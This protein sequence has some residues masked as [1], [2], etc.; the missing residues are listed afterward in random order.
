MNPLKVKK[1]DY[2]DED[3]DV[4]MYVVCLFNTSF[5]IKHCLISSR[6]PPKSN[7]TSKNKLTGLRANGN[8]YQRTPHKLKGSSA[9]KYFKGDAESESDSDND[10]PSNSDSKASG[11][12]VAKYKSQLH[13]TSNN[14]ALMSPFKHINPHRSNKSKR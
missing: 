4:F 11:K 3:D 2:F 12:Q 1:M 5:I 6:T 10:V 7:V 14:E 13:T 8:H 9:K